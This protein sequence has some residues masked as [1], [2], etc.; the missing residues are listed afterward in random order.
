M[1]QEAPGTMTAPIWPAF[2]RPSAVP[3]D[4]EIEAVVRRLPAAPR[5]LA[6]L[7]PHLQSLDFEI[8]EVTTV[9]RRDSSLT[10]R[11][12]DMA[13]SV[14]YL[15]ADAATSLEE[16]VARIGYRETHRLLGAVASLI[17]VGTLQVARAITL[18]A[19]L[20]FLGLGVPITEPSLGLLISNGYQYMLSGQYWISF[21]PGIALLLALVAINLVG[22]RLREVLNPRTQR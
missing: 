19:T 21:Y 7:A 2:R 20:P 1:I 15:G 11:L 6:E 12:I 17:V 16:A 5:I 9:L 18:E 10:A 13:N 22:D 14:A 3:T 8:G 4:P